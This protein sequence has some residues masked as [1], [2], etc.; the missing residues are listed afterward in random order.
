MKENL[1]M[2]A[3]VIVYAAVLF[4]SIALHAPPRLMLPLFAAGF[5]LRRYAEIWSARRK[6]LEHQR[7]CRSMRHR[8]RYAQ[9]NPGLWG[10]N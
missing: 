8:E 10:C 5:V 1:K 9:S 2:L 6:E 7:L 4:G 3:L